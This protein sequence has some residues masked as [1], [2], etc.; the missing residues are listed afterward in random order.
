MTKAR[1]G[2]TELEGTILGALGRAGG[3]T[4]YAVRRLFLSSLSEEWSGSAGA[5][6][7]AIARLEARGLLNA[8]AEADRRG[9]RTLLLTSKG[10]RALEDWLG[11]AVRATGAGTDPFRSRAGIWIEMPAS[12]RSKLL[13][14]VK[15]ELLRR[16]EEI[17]KT[18]PGLDA[19]DAI[20]L[21][22]HL[23]QLNDR[24]AWIETHG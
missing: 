17:T 9:G 4:A 21:K 20:M 2:A 12:Q 24:L 7:P 19:G 5:V 1:A 14:D 3:L 15:K 22:M 8:G 11:D 10:R 23:V 13:A 16:R 6:Y 18:E